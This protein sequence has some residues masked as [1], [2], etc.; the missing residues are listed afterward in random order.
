MKV[1]LRWDCAQTS[2]RN[3]R[4][5]AQKTLHVL[6]IVRLFS[7]RGMNGIV[8]GSWTWWG[9]RKVT[10]EFL[11][12]SFSHCKPEQMNIAFVLRGRRDG[13]GHW[14]LLL[15]LQKREREKKRERRGNY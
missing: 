1:Y 10:Q 11:R 15:L 2:A 8:F 5:H 14:L 13:A 12:G 9:G 7:P 6:H 3:S 4:L